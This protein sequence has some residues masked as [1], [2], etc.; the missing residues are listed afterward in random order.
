MTTLTAVAGGGNFMT[1]GTWSPSQV[2]TAADDCILAVGSGAVTVDAGSVCR[3][4]TASAY[5]STLTHTAGVT[6]T[7]GDATAGAGS[8]ALALGAGMTY[9][10][11]NTATSAIS[12]I[13]TSA[14]TQTVNTGG[15]T[16]GNLTI[17]GPATKVKTVSFAS[18]V[19]SS[20]TFT[21]TGNSTINRILLQSSVVGTARSITPTAFSFTNVD[22]MDITA[23]GTAWT[24]TSMGNALGNTNIT[25]DAPATQ[26]RSGA[27]GN[28]STAGSWTSRVPLP[29]DNVVIGAGASGTI[30]MDMPRLGADVG[31]T[32]FAGTAAFNSVAN[33][34]Y[35]SLVLGAGMT[36]S[37]TQTLALAARSSK[38]ITSNTRTFTQNLTVNAP[39]G[40]YT[41]GDA[42]AANNLAVA[43]GTFSTSGSNFSVQVQTFT[44]GGGSSV[45][46]TG[47]STVTLTGASGQ[48]VD[49]GPTANTTYNTSA[50]TFVISSA[51]ASAR[52]FAGR[53]ATFG[54][55]TYTVAGS[56]GSLTLNGANAGNIGTFATINFS[57]ASN[58]RSLL[59][60]AATTTTIT[61]LFN[62]VGTAGKLMTIDSAT[63]ATH[64]LTKPGGGAVSGMDYLNV[65]HSIATGA[66]WYA[67]AN[68]VD[69]G[70]NT[71]WFFTAAP[72]NSAT[73]F[74]FMFEGA[75]V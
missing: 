21:V 54:T 38:T 71:G 75:M 18:A 14:T 57:D 63:A 62:V 34:L 5:V 48:V 4:L 74:F 3:S 42:F 19:T 22:F 24:G 2:P 47:S 16:L 39:G 9:I 32:G 46:S 1:A 12:L 53:G 66:N 27:G 67:G 45:I 31:F 72:A 8:V 49:L 43:N 26:T 60:T 23:V 44:G 7:I 56:T 64:T 15:K 6:L 20:G 69:G 50:T 55:L 10:L 30:T 29:Q 37:G 59:F 41:L 68:S 17:T 13:S 25:F 40:T 35:G 11:G 36:V 28:Y 61:T 70:N 51:S 65:A 33:T 58:A 52:L 73:N